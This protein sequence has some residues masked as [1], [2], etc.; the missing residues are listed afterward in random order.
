M[1]TIMAHLAQQEEIQKTT[2]AQLATLVGALAVPSGMTSNPLTIRCQ[3]FHADPTMGIEEHTVDASDPLP[4]G[5]ALTQGVLDPMNIREIA[6]LKHSLQEIISQIHHVMISAPQIDMVLAAT[7]RTL[8]LHRISNVR[9]RCT[10]KFCLLS[11]SGGLDRTD[12]RRAFNI[13]MGRA[14]YPDDE[15]EAG[16]CQ[17]F[18]ESLTGPA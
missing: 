9:L 7:L 2:N 3:P 16:L 5:V 10:E 8:F 11:Y 15:K 1:D 12:H 18:V 6:T 17:L 13:G 4:S 14:N